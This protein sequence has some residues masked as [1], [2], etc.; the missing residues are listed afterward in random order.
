LLAPKLAGLAAQ[1]DSRLHAR[2]AEE[3]KSIVFET[4]IDSFAME[5]IA[6]L[7]MLFLPGSFISVSLV[8]SC[9]LVTEVDTAILSNL[10]LTLG[11][12]RHGFFLLFRGRVL[13][14]IQSGGSLLLQQYLS[15]CLFSQFG[16]GGS[17]WAKR[18]TIV[19]MRR[20]NNEVGCC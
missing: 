4:K 14:S 18:K 2:I 19:L 6:T 12:L 3:T 11:Y 9:V 17:E 10:F 8:F 20:R 16:T 5:T 7:A 15:R 13:P 1:R